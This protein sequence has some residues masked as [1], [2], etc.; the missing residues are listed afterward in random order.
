MRFL[1]I[2]LWLAICF[3][4]CKISAQPVFSGHHFQFFD[5]QQIYHEVS[6]SGKYAYIYSDSGAVDRYP[7]RIGKHQIC[8]NKNIWNTIS[9]NDSII[10]VRTEQN[11][12]IKLYRNDEIGDELISYYDWANARYHNGNGLMILWAMAAARREAFL[13]IIKE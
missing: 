2:I 5:W 8:F 6:F 9:S 13:T 4:A 10:L 3:W 12:T 1:K 11:D 7:T